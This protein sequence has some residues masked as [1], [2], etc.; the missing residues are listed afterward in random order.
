M[1]SE[2]EQRIREL[3]RSKRAK[4][5]KLKSLE[6]LAKKLS[7]QTIAMRQFAD[8]QSD[9]GS[10][11]G[12]SAV[13]TVQSVCGSGNIGSGASISLT[14]GTTTVS[15]T[16]GVGGSVGL[17][18]TSAGVWSGTMSKSGY[19][20]VTFSVTFACA[21]ITV[22]VTT[23]IT[24][25]TITGTVVGG[26]GACLLPANIA[27]SQSGG[28]SGS[29]T[30]NSSGVYTI[31]ISGSSGGA[32]TLTCTYGFRYDAVIATVTDNCTTPRTQNFNLPVAAG[33]HSEFNSGGCGTG[34][35]PQP[36]ANDL[37]LN[38]GGATIPFNISDVWFS[39]TYT[40]PSIDNTFLQCGD[41]TCHESNQNVTI[42]FQYGPGGYLSKSWAKC[43][44]GSTCGGK[45][46]P[47]SISGANT[48]TIS[49]ITSNVQGI[50]VECVSST[51][52]PFTRTFDS[53]FFTPAGSGATVTE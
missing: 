24:T 49:D 51:N 7:D 9:A 19:A 6:L 12:C 14:D 3:E 10:G 36:A 21:P 17:T 4:S 43:P 15:G 46:I 53:T 34:A 27:W 26:D 37:F 47:D 45:V 5:A 44:L 50:A 25:L 16:T 11:G 8:A 13:V 1:F 29:V 32:V 23:H 20:T 30:A 18:L 22:N 33:Y 39:H 41:P 38:H 35:C 52:S 42:W 2:R 28:S 48:W 40:L 31:T